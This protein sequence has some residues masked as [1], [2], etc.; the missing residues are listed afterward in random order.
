MD[1]MWYDM[2]TKNT[3]PQKT[4]VSFPLNVLKAL[5]AYM[6]RENMGLH[7]QSKVVVEALKEYL[8]ARGIPIGDGDEELFFDVIQRSNTPTEA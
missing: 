2:N 8:T 4:T 5:R 7:D 3:G 1:S 6:M